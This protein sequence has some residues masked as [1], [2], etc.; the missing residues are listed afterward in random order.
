M[1]TIFVDMAVFN[2]ALS[3]IFV[4][5]YLSVSSAGNNCCI[6][7]YLC[8]PVNFQYY[9]NLGKFFGGPT[10]VF[11]ENQLGSQSVKKL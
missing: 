7:K 8:R 1:S 5:G 10:E 11:L 6:T 2:E 3:T 4:G 9:A